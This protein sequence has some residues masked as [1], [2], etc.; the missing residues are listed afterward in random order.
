MNIIFKFS[1]NYLGAAEQF[2]VDFVNKIN[3][4]N[5]IHVFYHIFSKYDNQRFFNDLN[6]SKNDTIK[7]F[8]ITRN[9][10]E[11]MFVTYGGV[12]FVDSMRFQQDRLEKLTK[13]LNY[14]DYNH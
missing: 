9:S 14:H 12:R 6:N 1:G 2:C 5:F 13:S 7:L 3:Q 4:H 11:Y 8:L 10:E